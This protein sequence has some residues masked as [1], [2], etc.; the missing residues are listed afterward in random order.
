MSL[1]L[2]S[3][4]ICVYNAG[5]YC[6][7][8]LRSIVE[9]SYGRLEIL[10]VDDGSTDGCLDGLAD[11]D[12]RR[13]KVIRQPN[14]GKSVAM[15]QALSEMRGEF[16]AIQD[17]D[18]ISNRTRIERQVRCLIDSPDLAAVFCGHELVIGDRR[19]APR[20]REKS[21][22]ECRRDIEA[23]RMPAHDPTVMYRRSMVDGLEYQPQLWAGEGLDYILRVGEKYPMMVL[24]KCLYSYRVHPGSITRRDPAERERQVTEV[25]RQACERRGVE[26]AAVFPERLRD[27]G[28]RASSDNGLA[29]NFIE[30][31]IDLRRE[32]RLLQALRTGMECI[33][34]R[35][36]ELQY[37]KAMVYS[38]LPSRMLRSFRG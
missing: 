14:A 25:L 29:A 8:S 13:V 19:M 28:R 2:V 11:L 15:N 24:G 4:I 9:Q 3:V 10:V 31:A 35:P 33:A 30:S 20:F 37:Y 12:D 16:Y 21:R 34:I 5:E 32:G 26:F 23:F 36:T 1:P 22:E 6:A 7:P 27:S 17:A 38:L 18:D